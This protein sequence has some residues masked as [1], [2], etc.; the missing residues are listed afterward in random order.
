MKAGEQVFLMR[1]GGAQLKVTGTF[2]D[3]GFVLTGIK[4]R[5]VA[6]DLR[7]MLPHMVADIEREFIAACETKAMLGGFDHDPTLMSKHDEH[8]D[9]LD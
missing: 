1:L 3:E 4:M 6:S 9:G 8:R 2:S 5:G 7:K